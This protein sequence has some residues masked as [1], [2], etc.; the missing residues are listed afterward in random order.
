MASGLDF[1]RQFTPIIYAAGVYGFFRFLDEKSSDE[2]KGMI[3]HW[4]S[5]LDYDDAS[6][7]DAL[8]GAFDSIYTRP[9][10]SMKAFVRSAAISMALTLLLAFE[11]TGVGFGGQLGFL[12]LLMAL[13]SNVLSDYVSLFFVRRWLSAGGH[14]PV[15]LIIVGVIIGSAVILLFFELKEVVIGIFW[16]GFAK[17]WD[18]FTYFSFERLFMMMDEELVLAALVVHLWLPLLGLSILIIRSQGILAKPV[19]LLRWFVKDG[20]N[21]PFEIIGFVAAGVV[22]VTTALLKFLVGAAS[23]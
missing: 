12:L 3:K 13:V 9:L 5:K 22:L 21:H 8:V 11:Q 17:G 1:I 23:T 6:V 16:F 7:A 15:A 10:W 20:S 18:L 2:A 14:S 19:Q 4:L